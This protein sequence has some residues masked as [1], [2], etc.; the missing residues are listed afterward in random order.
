[1]DGSTP[2]MPP[3]AGSPAPP[4]LPVGEPMFPV[5]GGTAGQPGR[6]EDGRSR[7]VV[8]VAVL[9]T[10][11]VL[12]AVVLVGLRA[13]GVGGGAAADSSGTS[14]GDLSVG[15]CYRLQ[16]EDRTADSVGRVDVVSCTVPHD[17]QVYATVPLDF[18]AYPADIQ[19]SSTADAGC[20]DRD[21]TALDPAVADDETISTTW[22]APLEADWADSPH[23]ATCVIESDD[24][25]GLTRSWTK[26]ASA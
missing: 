6:P 15:T 13:L 21:A 22:Y 8:V 25:N 24:A 3:A 17:G 26:A 4:A 7:R 9:A 10:L 5:W 12:V 18:D 20:A 11:L 1:M 19:L 14:I 23:V 2:P 16:P